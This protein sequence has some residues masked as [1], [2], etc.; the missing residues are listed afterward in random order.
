MSTVFFSWLLTWEEVCAISFL[1]EE[2]DI[3]S[4]T[5]KENMN[6]K[7]KNRERRGSPRVPVEVK[8]QLWRDEKVEM[9][10]KGL[11]KNINLD[12]MCIETRFE[13]AEGSDL[14]FSLCLRKKIRIN[15][16]GKIIWRAKAGKVMRY[17][18]KFIELDVGEKPKLYHFIL[19][20]LFLSECK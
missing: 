8:I 16:Y 14:V 12:G 2:R 19:V 7:R 10:S 18:I 17:G 4:L 11:I 20:S 13:Y 6:Q 15:I 1:N 9:R 5:K 3:S